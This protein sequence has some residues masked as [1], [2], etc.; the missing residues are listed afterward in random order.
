MQSAIETQR[1]LHEDLQKRLDDVKHADKL[2]TQTLPWHHFL[3]ELD[4]IA[5][6]TKSLEGSVVEDKKTRLVRPSGRAMVLTDHSRGCAGDVVLRAF[7]I[8]HALLTNHIRM[9]TK[10]IDRFRR[11]QKAQ[12]MTAKFLKDFN[13]WGILTKADSKDE[14]SCATSLTDSVLDLNY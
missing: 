3:H 2:Q 8:D 6:D 14:S 11:M 4:L 10:E 12:E 7:R 9:L 1:Q 5:A 13:A